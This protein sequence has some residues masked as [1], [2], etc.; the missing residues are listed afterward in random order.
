MEALIGP[1]TVNTI[2]PETLEA[3]RDHGDTALL[4][5]ADI[6]QASWVLSEL[7]E[8]GINLNEITAKLEI[9]GVKKFIL[10]YDKLIKKISTLNFKN[11]DKING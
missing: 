10:S 9:E 1:N 11:K 7:S 2:S 3:Y 6:E 5:E 4:L 8:I